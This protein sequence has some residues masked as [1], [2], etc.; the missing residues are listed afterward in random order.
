MRIEGV[1]LQ[2]DHGDGDVGTVVGDALA[3]GEQV[4]EREA[5]VQRADT[6]LQAVDVVQLQLVAE[7]VD[8]LLERLDVVGELDV[9][10]HERAHG[11][12][13]DLRHGGHHHTQLVRALVREMHLLFVHLLGGLGNVQRMVADAL[14]VADRVQ[15]LGHVGGLL[16]VEFLTRDFNEVGAELVLIVVDGFLGVLYGAERIVAVSL[17]QRKRIEQVLLRFARHGVRRDTAL[18]DGQRGVREEALL[19]PVHVLGLSLAVLLVLDE[20]AHHLLQQTDE[21]RKHEYGGEAEEG[22]HHGDADGRHG[23]VQEG[24]VQKR[25]ERV[26]HARPDD[27]AEYVDEQIDERGALAVDVRAERGQQHRH[28]RADGDAHRDWKRNGKV[29]RPRHRQRLQNTDGGRRALQH[30]REQR[31]D[32]NAEQGIGELREQ[33]DERFA[34]P[35]GRDRAAHGLHAEHEH[36][37]AEQNVSHVY[38]RLLFGDHAQDDAHHGD[39]AGQRFG[40]QQRYPA[41]A[42]DV[43]QAEDP[44]GDARAEDGAEHD[45]DRLPHLHHAGVDKAHY[46]DRSCGGG[47]DHGGDAGAEQYAFQRGT[48]QFIEDDL[49]LVAG[50]FFQPVPHQGHAEQKQRHAAQQGDHIGNPQEFHAPVFLRLFEP[51]CSTLLYQLYQKCR[52]SGMDFA[53][54]NRTI[55][56]KISAANLCRLFI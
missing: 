50:D 37:E 18:L 24:K 39:D 14:Q 11:H 27:D 44:A 15:V 19:Q 53:R 8:Q 10:F 6:G 49:K 20:R 43:R 9:V 45:A 38:M 47:L 17:Q 56:A 3:V 48:G 13:Q 40:G 25:I 31:A 2:L 12:G 42:A 30:A 55:P 28:G 36:R 26:K 16:R 33:A 52:K 51:L 5:V 46:H 35:Q 34:L 21:R 41:G 22:V 54:K 29:N 32:Q 23:R 7:V 4:V 1:R